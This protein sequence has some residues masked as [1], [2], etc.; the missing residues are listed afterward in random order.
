MSPK[1]RAPREATALRSRLGTTGESPL[2]RWR[3]STAKAKL[4]L[5]RKTNCKLSINGELQ[6]YFMCFIVL[7]VFFFFFAIWH[8]GSYL[9]SPTK[10]Q[11]RP[12]VLEV[13]S[14]NRWTTREV[15]LHFIFKSASH[16]E[17]CHQMLL[18]THEH[19]AWSKKI[20]TW[21]VFIEF[22]WILLLSFAFYPVTTLQ[23]NH[24][25]EV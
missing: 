20:F 3:C 22:F 13:Q 10:D 1:P 5:D 18:V 16:A 11:T 14:L 24:F 23:I 8:V 2:Q 17:K 21:K 19:M 6:W 12:S 4:L 7:L 25:I 9:T 15:P